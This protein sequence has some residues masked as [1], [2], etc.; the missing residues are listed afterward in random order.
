MVEWARL[1]YGAALRAQ[2]KKTRKER[3]P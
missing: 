3:H 1:A 2:R